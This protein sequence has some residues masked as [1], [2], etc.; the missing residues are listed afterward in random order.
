VESLQVLGD[1]RSSDLSKLPGNVTDANRSFLGRY[2]A[3]RRS[4]GGPAI[5]FLAANVLEDRQARFISK[6]LE[7]FDEHRSPL[8]P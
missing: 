7:D 1:R 8:L 3:I 6:G 2:T 4:I 5:V